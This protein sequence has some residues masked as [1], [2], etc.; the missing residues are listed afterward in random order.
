MSP[1]AASESPRP[2]NAWGIAALVLALCGL[3]TG[4]RVTP[5]SVSASILAIIFGAIGVNRA[6]DGL[7]TNMTMARWGMWLGIVGTGATV[8]TL[9]YLTF[10]V[11]NY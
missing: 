5:V 6:K 7:A 4:F 11:N 1:P 8:I 3:A 10:I 2:R 9:A